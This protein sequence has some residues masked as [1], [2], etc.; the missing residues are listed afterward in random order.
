[1]LVPAICIIFKP[2]FLKNGK[3]HEII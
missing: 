2:S 1:L 3:K